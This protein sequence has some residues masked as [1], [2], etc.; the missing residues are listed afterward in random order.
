M[1][2]NVN[3][4]EWLKVLYKTSIFGSKW[5]LQSEAIFFSKP[6]RRFLHLIVYMSSRTLYTLSCSSLLSIIAFG[7]ELDQNKGLHNDQE[8]IAGVDVRNPEEI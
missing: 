3:P 6:L 7:N 2:K 1:V 4:E 5:F 8:G